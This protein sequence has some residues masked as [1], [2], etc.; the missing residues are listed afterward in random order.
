MGQYAPAEGLEKFVENLRTEYYTDKFGGLKGKDE[1][2]IDDIEKIKDYIENAYETK[3]HLDLSDATKLGI[4]LGILENADHIGLDREEIE[5]KLE[6]ITILSTSVYFDTPVL[7]EIIEL[8]N[9]ISKKDDSDI[10]T[11]KER[12]EI[13]NKA[14]QWAGILTRELE[15]E[16]RLPVSSKGFFDVEKAVDRPEKLFRPEVWKWLSDLP[17][18]DI[19]EACRCLAVDSSTASTMLSLRAVEECLRVWYQNEE[20]E[21]IES[22]AWGGVLSELEDIYESKDE[23]PAVLTNLDY[24]RMKRNEVNHPDVSP[25]WTEAE[26]TLYIVRNTITE[27][28]EALPEEDHAGSDASELEKNG[29]EESDED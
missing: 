24:L 15:N 5:S 1:M 4:L 22:T 20:G 12:R 23:T 14:D 9:D 8:R 6:Q 10:V 17:R 11:E 16:K 2:G 28:Y 25:R 27:I 21:E 18:E 26:A 3:E 7:E 13:A 29:G 19:A